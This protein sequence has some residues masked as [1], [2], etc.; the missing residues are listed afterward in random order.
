M[1]SSLIVSR[2]ARGLMLGLR[3]RR[4]RAVAS[5]RDRGPGN[6]AVRVHA[7]RGRRRL[8]AGRVLSGVGPARESLAHRHVRPELRREPDRRDPA[9]RRPSQSPRDQERGAGAHWPPCSTRRWA[10]ARATSRISSS[11]RRSALL[12]ETTAVRRLPFG[13]RRGCRMPAMRAASASTPPTSTSVWPSARPS[14]PFA[15][16][17]TSGLGILP[18]PGAWRSPERRR[19]LYGMSVARA[20]RT[21]IEVVGELNGR[22]STRNG[23]PPVG[24]ESRSRLRF[25]GRYTEAAVQIDAAFGIGFTS[26]IRPGDSRLASPG[27]SRRSRCSDRHQSSRLR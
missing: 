14:N 18:D 8:R 23:T 27:S 4:V 22:V 20:V 15:S 9:R 6:R 26:T 16:S 21:G 3:P 19:S 11:A 2:R 25:G 12:S 1:K 5:A 24:T 13:S 17:A 10:T 7:R